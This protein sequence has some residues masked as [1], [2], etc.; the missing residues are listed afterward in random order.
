MGRKRSRQAVLALGVA[1]CLIALA[2]VASVE[3]A[4]DRRAPPVLDLPAAAR[5]PALASATDPDAHAGPRA[6][7]EERA[8]TDD[9][10]ARAQQDARAEV[11]L[12][13]LA[14]VLE[15]PTSSRVEWERTLRAVSRSLG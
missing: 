14:R 3:L 4:A 11:T 8:S 15:D 12:E 9:A 5:A 10:L 7:V 6:V 13:Q 1:A 2:G